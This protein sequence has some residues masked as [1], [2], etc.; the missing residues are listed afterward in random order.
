[1]ASDPDEQQKKG[2]DEERERKGR[3]VRLV[4]Q[5]S[6]GCHA[7]ADEKGKRGEGKGWD[8]MGKA[9]SLHRVE[10]KEKR[11]EEKSKESTMT[12]EVR[13]MARA[14]EMHVGERKR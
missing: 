5:L 2:G 13:G 3:D 9:R 14:R 10:R 6:P 11:G 4:G 8:G 7:L 12:K 1:M